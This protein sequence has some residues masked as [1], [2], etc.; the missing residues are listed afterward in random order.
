MLEAVRAQDQFLIMG[1]MLM[2]G[3]LLIMGNLFADIL[4]SAC[5]PRVRLS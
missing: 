5:D 4:L 1:D 2:S 3:I